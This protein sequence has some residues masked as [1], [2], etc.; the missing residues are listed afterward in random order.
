MKIVAVAIPPRASGMVIRK[1]TWCHLHPSMRAAS[2][3]S[4]GIDLMNEVMSQTASGSD[5]ESSRTAP[6]IKRNRVRGTEK[7]SHK[8]KN[9][10]C[11]GV[12][13]P[14]NMDQIHFGRRLN[15]FKTLVPSVKNGSRAELQMESF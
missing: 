3:I 13:T 6:P 1:K 2:T 5:K 8:R 10:G 9:S 15:L 14:R 7:T 4:P 11:S 12:D